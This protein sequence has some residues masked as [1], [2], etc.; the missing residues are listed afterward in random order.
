MSLKRRVRQAV[1]AMLVVVG[2]AL[3]WLSPSVGP[4]LIT[5]ALGIVVELVGQI[6]D[7]RKPP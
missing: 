5:F 4:G 2:G 6:L 1:A 7:R 3:M